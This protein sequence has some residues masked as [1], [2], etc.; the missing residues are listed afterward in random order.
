MNILATISVIVGILSALIIAVD[1]SSGRS[2]S[3]RI[4]NTVWILTG[5][6]GGVL[7]LVAYFWFGRQQKRMEMPPP[8]PNKIKMEMPMENAHKM[9]MPMENTHAMDMGMPME[10]S[11]K[12]EMPS[13]PH[14]QSVTLSTLHCGAGC[15]LADLIGEW[16]LYLVAI[17]IGGSLLLGSVVV[18]YILALAIGVCFQYVAIREMSRSL[19]RGRVLA[20]AFKADV[21]SLTAWQV[22]MFG[23]MALVIFVIMPTEVLSRTSWLFWFMM[24][25]AMLAGFAVSF[26]VNML[27]IRWG[28]KKAM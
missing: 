2:Q 27:L 12:M 1:L 8:N 3:M 22:G 17:S 4:M 10:N 23:F 20:T 5:L 18:D 14:W 28:V 15:T 6:W 13:H 21:L 24:Q 25:I 11:H 16:F 9:G 26:P 7:A 19:P